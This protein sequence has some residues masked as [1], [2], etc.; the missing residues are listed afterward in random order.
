M[1]S[2][3][4]PLLL[5]LDQGLD[6]AL[7]L[8]SCM[9]LEV[10]VDCLSRH[11]SDPHFSMARNGRG[12]L[13]AHAH[14]RVTDKHGFE[15]TTAPANEVPRFK[16]RWKNVK[17]CHSCSRAIAGAWTWRAAGSHGPPWRNSWRTSGEPSRGC[18][19]VVSRLSPS[20]TARRTAAGLV[21]T[22]LVAIIAWMDVW[23]DCR[24]EVGGM[25][26]SVIS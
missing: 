10:N 2:L 22:C 6:D 18:I 13:Q 19:R 4:L 1:L 16:L 20:D 12:I 14:R 8:Q 11:A 7:H 24:V 23:G 17:L 25:G 5:G 26:W 21:W 15:E 9:K 3:L